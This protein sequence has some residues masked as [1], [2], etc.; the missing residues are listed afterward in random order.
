MFKFVDLPVKLSDIES[1][2]KD[3]E[4]YYPVPSGEFYPSITTV[5]S[6]KKAAFFKEWRQ[7]VGE[8]AANRK[9]TRATGRG[10]AFHSIVESYLKN[11]H[12]SP[13]TVSPLPF[14]L[15]QVAKLFL[16]A[17]IIF[18]FL[19][20]LYIPIIFVLLVG[21]TVLLNLITNLL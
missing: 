2:D 5:T 21:L 7:K 17:L 12:I 11:E 3:G 8:E 14:T 1:I 18:I 15:F 6:F 9:T 19:K 13:D 20:V 10:T 4:R 16:I